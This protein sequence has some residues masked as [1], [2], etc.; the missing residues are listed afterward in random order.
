V[1]N[2]TLLWIAGGTVL[3]GAAGAAI[4]FATRKPTSSAGVPPKV[5]G[6]GSSAMPSGKEQSNPTPSYQASTLPLELQTFA[7]WLAQNSK[8][9]NPDTGNQ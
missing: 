4:Y 2:E 5:P 7:N 6:G 9:L 1:K 8:L 3:V